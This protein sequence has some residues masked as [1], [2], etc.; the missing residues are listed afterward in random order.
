MEHLAGES[1]LPQE[2]PNPEFFYLLG[3]CRESCQN[4][5]GAE[6]AFQQA[7]QVDSTHEPSVAA[8]ARVA[9]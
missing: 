9:S 8:L 7:L 1:G 2:M 4:F 5:T 6:R 3:L